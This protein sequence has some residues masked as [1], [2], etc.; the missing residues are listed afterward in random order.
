MQY[1]TNIPQC[2]PVNNQYIQYSTYNMIQL[3]LQCPHFWKEAQCCTIILDQLLRNICTTAT[4]HT[5][6]LHSCMI[7]LHSCAIVA[8]CDDSQH[9]PS[10]KKNVTALLYK[11]TILN[12]SRHV[13]SPLL[14]EYSR[15]VSTGSLV[16][17]MLYHTWG[18]QSYLIFMWGTSPWNGIRQ[19]LFC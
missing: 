16:L 10:T 14:L 17:S 11:R 12:M 7:V 13:H 5:I 1:P 4:N 15:K 19:K 18:R 9:K 2:C 8:L 6:L 3:I